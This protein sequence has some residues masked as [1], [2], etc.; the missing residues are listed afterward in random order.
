[1]STLTARIA[2][3]SKLARRGWLDTM[4]RKSLRKTGRDRQEE[5]CEE[6]CFWLVLSRRFPPTGASSRVLDTQ[7]SHLS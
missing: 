5:Q 7:W 4:M 6:V 1:M 3:R 2:M